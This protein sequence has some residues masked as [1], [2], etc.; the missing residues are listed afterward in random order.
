MRMATIRMSCLA[1]GL[2]VAGSAAALDGLALPEVDY[3]VLATEA[4]NAQG[5]VPNGWRMEHS[6]RGDLDRDGREDLLL[7]LRMHD[8]RNILRNDGLGTDELDTNP[9]LLVV[10]FREGARYRR[11]LQDHVLVPR[12]DDPVADDYLDIEDPVA[13]VRGTA[14][15]RLHSWR[16][17]GGWT[18][19][20]RRFTFRWQDGCFRLVGFDHDEV[21]RN[22]GR[23]E[24]TSINYLTH[25][26]TVEEGSIEYDDVQAR[27]VELPRASLRCLATVGSGME[28]DPALPAPPEG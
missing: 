28:F 25:R 7:V 6:A 2:S 5:F 26:A 8:P 11:V 12:H 16:S 1:Y 21:Q 14:R 19:W 20:N 3:P 23:T 22:S 27:F 4:G 9:R 15:V 17:A 24:R 13:I 18:T 10:A